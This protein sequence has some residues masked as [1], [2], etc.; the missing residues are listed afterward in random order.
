MQAIRALRSFPA[1]GCTH[2]HTLVHNA[3]FMQRVKLCS[4]AA[5]KRSV[6][7]CRGPINIIIVYF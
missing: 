5:R 2:Y 1:S 6:A 3:V 4:L 7:N